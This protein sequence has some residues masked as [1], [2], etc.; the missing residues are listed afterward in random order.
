M[1]DYGQ[2]PCV[3][4]AETA[5]VR[6]R[7]RIGAIDCVA[8]VQKGKCPC[9]DMAA[10]TYKCPFR[11]PPPVARVPCRHWIRNRG[12]CWYAEHCNFLHPGTAAYLSSREGVS[13]TGNRN[14]GSANGCTV[15]PSSNFS[16]SIPIPQSPVR[17]HT[18]PNPWGTSSVIPA[19]VVSTPT[20]PRDSGAGDRTIGSPWTRRASWTSSGPPQRSSTPDV[21][22][23]P[24]RGMLDTDNTIF[25][26]SSISSTD[27][28]VFTG[29]SRIPAN[30]V[31]GAGISLPVNASQEFSTHGDAIDP[32]WGSSKSQHTDVGLGSPKQRRS[33]RLL[34]S[35]SMTGDEVSSVPAL[36]QQ[37]S[38]RDDELLRMT[39][40][41]AAKDQQIAFLTEQLEQLRAAQMAGKN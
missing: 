24:L 21:F 10:G 31:P 26:P 28:E 22:G 23:R 11:H 12:E 9:S 1:R 32:G 4:A 16:E 39:N 17:P 37:L 19:A 7:A 20:S 36:R 30:D 38:E 3:R 29:S 2:I 5:P 40:M 34:S 35:Q 8:W 27:D 41:L 13:S 14:D 33:S 25:G 18:N 15:I 6:Y